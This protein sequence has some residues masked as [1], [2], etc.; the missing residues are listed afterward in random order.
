M[1]QWPFARTGNDRDNHDCNDTDWDVVMIRIEAMK[2]ILEFL[3]ISAI[4]QIKRLM[5]EF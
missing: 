1:E 4:C 3:A 5:I 2:T